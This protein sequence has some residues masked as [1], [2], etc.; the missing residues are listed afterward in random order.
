MNRR[1][2]WLLLL[3]L[4]AVGTLAQ[5]QQQAKV[6]KIGWLTSSSATGNRALW[7]ALGELGYVEGKN[8]IIEYGH[9]DNKLD[10]LPALADELVR[11]KV[12]VL[13]VGSTP[14]ALAAKKATGTIPIVFY[15]VSDPVAAGWLI[16]WPRPGANITGFTTIMAVS[17]GKRLEL[18]KETVPKLSRAA[19]LWNPQV[20]GSTQQWKESQ[21]AG[22]DLGLQLH[23]MEASG[24]GEYD[25]AF[26][27]S[28]K[29]RSTALAVT[30]DPVAASNQKLIVELAAKHRL[31]AV[32]PRGDFVTS[33]GLMAYGPDQ[34]E[35]YRRIASMVDKILKGTK[36]AEIPV[37]QPT[38]FEFIINLKAANRSA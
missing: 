17:A 9:A 34:G 12:D 10:R 31:P 4:L 5:A 2:L 3:F 30:Q 21:L 25:R 14:A 20:P 38:K 11:L 26:K 8:I 13:I 1:L 19:V 7:Q 29:A 35:P 27:E 23:S 24:A 6:A 22:R 18:L 32:Y 16:A 15:N 36:P 37:E 28:A 33:G